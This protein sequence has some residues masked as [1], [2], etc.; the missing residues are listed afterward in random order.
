MIDSVHNL[1]VGEQT[2]LSRC[3]GGRGALSRTDDEIAGWL[4]IT[5]GREIMGMSRLSLDQARVFDKNRT[6]IY[7]G[8]GRL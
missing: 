4:L 7:R 5:N 8:H 2:E 3:A 6:E 1:I